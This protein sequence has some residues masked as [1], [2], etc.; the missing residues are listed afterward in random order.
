MADLPAVFHQPP[1]ELRRMTVS[2]LAE[3]RRPAQ[4]RVKGLGGLR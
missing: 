4:E 2:E 1:P 3:C